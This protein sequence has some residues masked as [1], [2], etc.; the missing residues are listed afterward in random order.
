[1]RVTVLGGCGAWPAAG[2]AC[3]GYL[4]EHDGYRL[5]V[6]PGYAV[7]PRL[8]ASVPA[9]E[10]DAVYVTHGHPDHCADLNPLLR[11]RVLDD[12]PPPP[13]PVYAPAGALDAVL[14]LDGEWV[15][16]GCVL[17]EIGAGAFDLGPFAAHAV[18]LPHHL[19]NLGIRLTAD[20][21]T[22]AYTGDTGPDPAVVELARDAD[23]F[24]AE[25][26]YPHEAPP[27]LTSAR[28]AAA[29]AA[30]AGVGRLV[31]THLWP[32]T[33]PAEALE[34]ASAFDGPVSVALPGVLQ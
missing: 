11:A 12:S 23:V 18:A 15:T 4:V 27:L 3:S 17:R 30:R 5:L 20:G 25:A 2:Q 29:Q 6:D 33:D 7:L 31:L 24:L 19:P 16:A 9:R 21:R 28:D 14:A 8:P 26:T 34:A 32:G 10:V 22:L 13:L 1:M